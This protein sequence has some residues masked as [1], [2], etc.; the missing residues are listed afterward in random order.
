MVLSCTYLFSQGWP[1]KTHPYGLK[2]TTR[3]DQTQDTLKEPLHLSGGVYPETVLPWNGTESVWNRPRCGVPDYP[4]Q[5]QSGISDYHMQK[6]GTFGGKQRRKR[7]VVFG[8]RW[9]KTDL[10]YK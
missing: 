9:D 4:T 10:T 3:F 2:K 6:G 1:Q 5:K 8:G 7:F